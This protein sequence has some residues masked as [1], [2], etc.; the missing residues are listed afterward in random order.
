[1]LVDKSAHHADG[2][3]MQTALAHTG[4]RL[5]V[6]LEPGDD[7]LSCLADACRAAGIDQAVIT[8]FSGAF[9][10]VW[11]IAADHAPEDPELPLPERCRVGY[12][13]GIGSGTVTRDANGEHVVHVHVAVGA[14]DRSGVAVAGHLLQAETHYV[15]EVVLDEILEPALSRVVHPEASGVAILHLTPCTT[16]D[17]S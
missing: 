11:V 15:V 1:M 2:E 17:R 5:L 10:S 7:V 4:R 16:P 3:I 14:K 12:C 13:E 8:T 6:A 9:R